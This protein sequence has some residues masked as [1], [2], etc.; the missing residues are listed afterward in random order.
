MH[1]DVH[2]AVVLPPGQWLHVRAQRSEA[3]DQ[4][5]PERGRRA[6]DHDDG[7]HRRHDA[8]GDT[9][10]STAWATGPSP[11]AGDVMVASTMAVR[12]ATR[13]AFTSTESSPTGA[14][15]RNCIDRSAVKASEPG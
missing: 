7:V 11:T 3:S 6:L 14:P 9:K 2:L 1:I 13:R 15:R 4:R 10:V 12:P 8:A 5:R